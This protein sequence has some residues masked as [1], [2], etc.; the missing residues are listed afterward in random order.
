MGARQV[1]AVLATGAAAAQ[2]GTALPA[3]P[4]ERRAPAVQGC[5]GRSALHRHDCD[6]G[7][8]RTS[9]ARAGQRVHRRARGRAA[10]L[11]RAQQ[12]HPAAARRW[13]RP[14]GTPETMSLWAGQG[15][16]PGRPTPAAEIIERAR[17]NSSAGHGGHT[18]RF[19]RLT[20]LGERRQAGEGEYGSTSTATS[21]SSRWSMSA[22]PCRAGPGAG[23]GQGGRDQ[24]GRGQDPRGPA[25][26]RW[27]ATF[28]SGQGSDLAGV[29][30][31]TGPGVTGFATGRRR[32]SATPTTGPA[33]PNTSWSRSRT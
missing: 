23:P 19:A 24:L 30:A 1:Q 3:Q 11:P 17:D 2:C 9:C 7:F 33:R 27:P 28:P 25:A 5:A 13:L 22:D 10:R 12:R 31:G 20:G 16:P 14:A 26:L 6:Q 32:S 8:Q 21:T 15:V 18:G 4:G 29:V